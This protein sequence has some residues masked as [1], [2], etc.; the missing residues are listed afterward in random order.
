MKKLATLLLAAGMVLGSFAGAQAIDWKVRGTW[1]IEFGVFDG[2][3][4]SKNS[5]DSQRLAKP[6]KKLQSGAGAGNYDTF[7]A[8]QRFDIWL[9]AVASENL[10]GSLRLEIGGWQWG[11]HG[12]SGTRNAGGAMGERAAAIGVREAYIDWFVP[13]TELKFRM[14]LHTITN[15]SFTGTSSVIAEQMTGV[16][17]SYKFN[18]NVSL[19]AFW[20]RP[21][22]DNYST[23]IGNTPDNSSSRGFANS[24]GDNLDVFGLILPLSFDG[25]K[26][27]PWGAVA[28]IGPNSITRDDFSTSYF[29]GTN[30]M[31]IVRAGML[32]PYSATNQRIK[33]GVLKEYSTAWWAGLTGDITV[34][35]P[36]RFAWDVNYGSVTYPDASYL[37]RQ[38]WLLN[39]LAEYKFDWGVPGLI[40]W[41]GSGDD[42]NPR[43][44][45]E[46]MPMFEINNPDH[47]VSTFGL[48][49][50]PVIGLSSLDGVMG[51]DFQAGT[52]GVG[53]RIRDVSF[54]EDLKH[55]L[56]VNLF[57][58]TND[59]QMAKYILGK[60][61]AGTAAN[62]TALANFNQRDF[63]RGSASAGLNNGLYLTRQDYGVEVTFDT[64]YKIYENLTMLLELGYIHLWLDQSRAVWGPGGTT[65]QGPGGVNVKDA[66][67]AMLHFRYQF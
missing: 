41:Y 22:N 37:N 8:G 20:G 36:F 47:A 33:N 26:V 35:D 58:G 46:Q 12:T 10:S 52:W 65:G 30:R 53:L 54:L 32:A 23:A 49:G 29:G 51:L 18:D 1:A 5:T 24:F 6:R 39:L 27:T 55:T 63:N 9:D 19:A 67:K 14:G 16:T 40:F 4:F 17:A 48:N 44:G 25:V 60:K 43:N 50:S 31:S 21:Y 15:P 56:R 62:R 13:Q 38:G 66:L 57:G 42:S 2:L 7:E 45:S 3:N 59:P 64:S 34:A 61:T 28:A 11:Q